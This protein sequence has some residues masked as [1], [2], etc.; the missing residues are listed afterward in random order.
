M[1]DQ[2]LEDGFLELAIALARENLA[3]GGRPFGALVVKDGSVIATGVNQIAAWQDPTA[4]AEI[5][6]IREA[7]KLLGPDLG[8]CTIYASG[9]PCPMCLAAMHLSGVEAV[10][11]AYSNDAAEPFGLSTAAVYADL[12]RPFDQQRLSI[13]QLPPTD[14]ASPEIYC[15]WQEAGSKPRPLDAAFTDIAAARPAP[16]GKGDR[17]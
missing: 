11:F 5:V 12:A 3:Q 6:A 2:M 9:H 8:G 16:L 14:A 4:H 17:S 15:I 1:T 13:A 7:S 10:R